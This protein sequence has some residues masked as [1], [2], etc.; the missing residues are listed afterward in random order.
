MLILFEQGK[1]NRKPLPLPLDHQAYA[2]PAHS[3]RTSGSI[4]LHDAAV[5]SATSLMAVMN[6][7]L[8]SPQ[9][10]AHISSSQQS[11]YGSTY[12][13]PRSH[14]APSTPLVEAPS[15]EPAELPGS[16]PLGYKKSHSSLPHMAKN[17]SDTALVRSHDVS[18]YGH[19]II[20]PHSSPQDKQ[21]PIAVGTDTSTDAQKQQAALYPSRDAE[22]PRSKSADP[23][24]SSHGSAAS[25]STPAGTGISSFQYSKRPCLSVMQPPRSISPNLVGSLVPSND[26][27]SSAVPRVVDT[28]GYVQREDSESALLEEIAHLRA[29]Q[30]EHVRSLKEAHEKELACQRSYIDFLEKRRAAGSHGPQFD[31]TKLT[32]DT[33]HTGSKTD[34]HSEPS[35]TTLKSFELSLEDQK[36]ASQEALAETEALKRKLS[37]C[38]KAQVDAVEIRRERDHLKDAADRSDRRITQLKD[39]I[40]KAKENDRALRNQTTDLEARLVEANNERIDVLEGFHDACS[41]VRAANERERKLAHELDGMR[42]QV[43]APL[44]PRGPLMA[45]PS[46]TPQSNKSKHGRALSDAGTLST[47]PPRMDP[48]MRQLT[49]SRRALSGK[50]ARIKELEAT[51]VQ[52]AERDAN[53]KHDRRRLSQLENQLEEQKQLTCAAQ[54]DSERYNSLLHN[55]L[56]RQSRQAAR[57]PHNHAL[58]IEADA[59]LVASEK[60][61]RL[62]SCDHPDQN[63]P[64][65]EDASSMPLPAHTPATGIVALLEKELD[66]CIKEIV[67]Y[68][69]DVKGT[70]LLYFK[71][72]R[73]RR[74]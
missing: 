27:S 39:I 46:E 50:E 14:T 15:R 44:G 52:C 1:N 22:T 73:A 74:N 31:H 35:A 58:K 69:L 30:D 12:A 72:K 13:R 48:I 65:P 42:G 3:S 26:G 47:T 25:G 54:S 60:L 62:K 8:R 17:S 67:M 68:K 38:R 16:L 23:R 57:N 18:S 70:L 61:V 37:L 33:S 6:D 11:D 9:L 4:A 56:R 51:L 49:E 66:H 7:M 2:T 29:S 40:R 71:S 64:G 21:H 59:D 41:Q 32:I 43:P 28:L 36:R 45:L 34:L 20:R 63:L 5:Q 19:E 55:E 53:H 10:S 24:A